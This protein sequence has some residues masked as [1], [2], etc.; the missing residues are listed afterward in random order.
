MQVIY[1]KSSL[2]E[3]ANR[4]PIV[5]L[6]LGGPV[7]GL[8]WSPSSSTVI[9]A[10]TDEGRVYVYDLFLRKC[11][12]LCVQNLVQRRRFSLA[13]VTFSPFQPVILVG[14]EK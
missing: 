4:A 5:T 2:K 14:G 11:Q 13:C 7:V 6:D 1:F 8:T 12:P 9:V 3:I 10:V